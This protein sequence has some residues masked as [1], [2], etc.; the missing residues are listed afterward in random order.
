MLCFGGGR[1]TYFCRLFTQE[2]QP[3]SFAEY[4]SPLL[5]VWL[6]MANSLYLS[7]WYPNIWWL[8][9]YNV[10]WLCAF[11]V[12]KK[13]STILS[14]GEIRTESGWMMLILPDRNGSIMNCVGWFRKEGFAQYPTIWSRCLV[15]RFQ[16]KPTSV[17]SSFVS[18]SSTPWR[19][20]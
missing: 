12:D 4:L 10:V 19:I 11:W 5:H 15:P 3:W 2:W 17:I 7:Q 14:L 6:V 20:F 13:T 9:S 18:T 8:D 1:N 16:P